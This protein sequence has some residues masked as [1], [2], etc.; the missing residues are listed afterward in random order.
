MLLF[1]SSS[2]SSQA[3]NA[4]KAGQTHFDVGILGAVSN[5]LV[6]SACVYFETGLSNAI[7]ECLRVGIIRNMNTKSEFSG[8]FNTS[9]SESNSRA[10]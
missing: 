10:P 6:K 3:E 7:L 9:E 1:Y 2:L 8:V 4:L 5:L